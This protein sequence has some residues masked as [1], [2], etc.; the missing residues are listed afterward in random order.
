[1]T[2]FAVVYQKAPAHALG[3]LTLPKEKDNNIAGKHMAENWQSTTE[4]VRR[5]ID[6]SNIKYK[7]AVNKHRKKLF[8]VGDQVMVFLWREIPSWPVQQVAIQEI[9]VVFD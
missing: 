9:W 2:P 3:L 7:Q 8:I 6:E 5:K 4:T 1:M